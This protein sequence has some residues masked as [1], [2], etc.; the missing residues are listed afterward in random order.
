M[1]GLVTILCHAECLGAWVSF[2]APCTG[3]WPFAS[4]FTAAAD[5]DEFAIACDLLSRSDVCRWRWHMNRRGCMDATL[6]HLVWL[7]YPKFAHYTF[8]IAAFRI[9]K[10]RS[11][12]NGNAMRLESSYALLKFLWLVV[13]LF[14]PCLPILHALIALLANIYFILLFGTDTEFLYVKPNTAHIASLPSFGLS[15][16]V[17]LALTLQASNLL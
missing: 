12:H 4:K 13:I 2:W 1:P 5:W 15:T 17:L 7:L 10:G 16:V 6:E 9:V 11:R 3:S 8:T 14:G